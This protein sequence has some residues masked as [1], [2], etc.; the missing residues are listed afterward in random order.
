M[1]RI[2]TKLYQGVNE[3]D[4]DEGSEWDWSKLDGWLQRIAGRIEK[5]IKRAKDLYEQFSGESPRQVIEEYIDDLTSILDDIAKDLEPEED[6]DE[7]EESDDTE[8]D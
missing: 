7:S 5:D 6:D 8:E 2:C 1:G 3:L 4:D